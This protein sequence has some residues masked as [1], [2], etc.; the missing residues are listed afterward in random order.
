MYS[1]LFVF[2]F[3][4]L[5]IDKYSFDF[6]VHFNTLFSKALKNQSAVLE[7]MKNCFGCGLFPR[8]KQ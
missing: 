1:I 5:F 8:R 7:F 3:Q 4:I 2:L 6:Y